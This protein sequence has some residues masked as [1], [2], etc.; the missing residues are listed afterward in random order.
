LTEYLYNIA[1]QANLLYYDEPLPNF[2][3]W[4]EISQEDKFEDDGLLIKDFYYSISDYYIKFYLRDITFRMFD[5]LIEST[6]I[7]FSRIH[8]STLPIIQRGKENEY[9]GYGMG[10]FDKSWNGYNWEYLV[11]NSGSK[12]VVDK[13]FFRRIAKDF[14]ENCVGITFPSPIDKFD[15]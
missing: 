15:V 12:E 13:F 14:L 11:E 1:F 6:S 3:P 7:F 5:E 10:L 8:A 2:K 4:I 9:E